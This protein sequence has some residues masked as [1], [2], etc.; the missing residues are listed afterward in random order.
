MKDNDNLIAEAMRKMH[1]IEI[2]QSDATIERVTGGA[3]SASEAIAKSQIHQ[4]I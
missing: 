4:T 3:T 2:M 1:Q